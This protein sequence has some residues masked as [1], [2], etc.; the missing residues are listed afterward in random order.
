MS[1]QALSKAG[2]VGLVTGI[3]GVLSAVLMLAWP[4]E[5][6]EGILRYPFTSNGFQ[7]IQTWFFVHHIGLVILLVAL[8]SSGAVGPGRVARGGAWLGVVAMGM[9]AGMELFAVPYADLSTKVANEGAIGTGYGVST[10]LIGLGMLAAGVG[11]LGAGVWSGWRRWIPLLLGVTLFLVVTP[12]MFGGYVVARLAI[13]SWMGLFAAL[14]WSLMVEV[15]RRRQAPA[16]TPGGRAPALAPTTASAPG[17]DPI[18]ALDAL[19]VDLERARDDA[20]A[21]LSKALPSDR[22]KLEEGIAAIEQ[23]LIEVGGKRDEVLGR[24]AHKRKLDALT[25]EAHALNDEA[26]SLTVVPNEDRAKQL[27]AR[28]EEIRAELESLRSK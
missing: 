19:I 14:G 28:A 8:A 26:Q 18:R 12:G 25:R 10:S 13:G 16:R 9:L 3:L 23:K 5:A 17:E 7:I 1:P 4:V 27:R 15:E 22:V 11:V 20:R 6:P 2:K 24:A 21:V